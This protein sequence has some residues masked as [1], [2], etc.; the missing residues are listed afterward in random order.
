MTTRQLIVCC[1][2]TNNNLTGGRADTNVVKVLKWV[3]DADQR[4]FY[5]PGVGNAGALPG[6]TVWD[7][8]RRRGE[9][10]AG[11][12]FGRGVYENI[13]EAYEFLMRC[14]QPG[15]ELYFFGFSRGS[16]TA[17]ST[18]GLVNQFGILQPHMQSMVP[19]L[20]HVYFSNRTGVHDEEN[21]AVAREI[22]ENFCSAESRAVK[23]HF[24][25]VWDTVASVG[26]WPFAARMTAR[27]TI[28]G[29][30]F[31]HVRQALALDE[32]RA[33]FKPRLYVEEIDSGQSVVQRWFRGAHCDA[34][35]GY[36]PDSSAISNEALAWM[37]VEA[38]KCG[39]RVDA[40]KVPAVQHDAIC[41]ALGPRADR[42]APHHPQ[43]DLR[44]L[45]V[46]GR[47]PHRA[48]DRG[49]RGRWAGRHRRVAH[50]ARQR[51]KDAAHLSRQLG[52]GQTQARAP[53]N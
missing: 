38:S 29:K 3:G 51:G 20:L 33:P 21:K 42:A 34:G 18:A 37:V 13:A 46:G 43:R 12:A 39:L 15:D 1:D 47:R 31:V 40:T 6:A 26:M 4:V 35:G 17:R 2:G 7:G 24:V 9:R 8:I 22:R 36:P 19:T 10:V 50:R 5:D 14:Y 28:K 16:F 25:G 49:G 45:P 52:V 53:G 32:H 27:P 11:L 23:I 44:Q 48:P 41:E 30:R